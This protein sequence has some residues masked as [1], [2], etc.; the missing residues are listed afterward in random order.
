MEEK[1]IYRIEI[2]EEDAGRRLDKFLADKMSQTFSR[3][4][5]QRLIRDK[6]VLVDGE[7]RKNNYSISP[8]EA[9]EIHMPAPTESDIMA[10]KIP[11]N[12]VYEDD[13]LLIVNKSS[14]MVVHPAPGNYSGTL[15]NALLSHCKNL[16]G[17]GGVIKPG[18]VHR[19][20]KG[21]S[22]LLVVAKN[23]R[24]HR[25]LAKQF[26]AKTARRVYVAIVKGVVQL[27]NG[28]IEAPIGRDKRDRKKMAVDFE[29]EK[30]R[31]AVTRYHVL[32]RFKDSTMVELV[33][34]TGRTHQVRVHMAHLGYP[35]LGD[36]SYG[37][38]DGLNRP[39]LHARVIGFIHPA[40][41]EYVEF[42]SELPPDMKK[43][44]ASKRV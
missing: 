30:S 7:P 4:F 26:K 29:S 23:D 17:I 24:S 41:N 28:I 42:K 20:D 1:D 31:T 22:G 6:H 21:T 38:R 9:V 33:L 8:G 36:V 34:G 40:T 35:V 37:T 25:L 11:L 43:L 13:D 5:L 39:M 14:D 19:L 3:A 16:S 12:I 27:D 2:I 44:I 15:V 32:E 18:I 10:E